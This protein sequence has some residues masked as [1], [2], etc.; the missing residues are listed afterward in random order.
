MFYTN[1]GHK[2]A[3]YSFR[4][5]FYGVHPDTPSLG[6]AENGVN[7]N[8]GSRS[9]PARGILTGEDVMGGTGKE[10]VRHV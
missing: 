3:A 10:G 1:K 4:P 2:T 6:G 8:K 5:V 9:L 7:V